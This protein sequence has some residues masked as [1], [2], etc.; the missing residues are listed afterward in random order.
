[1]NY[2]GDGDSASYSKVES[3]SPDEGLEIAKLECNMHVQKRVGNTLRNLKKDQLSPSV[4]QC[5]EAKGFLVCGTKSRATTHHD[6][7]ENR[8]KMF[9]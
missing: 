2:I 7:D 3:S 9:C 6:D 8:E 4:F 5:L 1:M